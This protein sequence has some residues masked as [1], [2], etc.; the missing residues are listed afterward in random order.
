MIAWLA[1]GAV[2]LAQPST[3]QA[4]SADTV[5]LAPAAFAVVK[6][7]L[8]YDRTIPLDAM[9]IETT[10]FP[11]HSRQRIVYRGWRS[12]LPAYLA[13]PKTG[14][15][16]F[17]VVLL[18]HA[19]GSSKETWWQADGF[20]YGAVLRDSLLRAGFAV[21][22]IDTQLHGDRAAAA[23]YVPVA[24][25]FLQRQWTH[26]LRDV[27]A[28]T[29]VDLRRALD[30]LETR[31]DIEVRRASV[32]GTSMGG[33]VAALVAATDDRIRSAVICVAPLDESRF[34]PL[35]A[36][37]IAPWLNRPATLIVAGRTDEMIPLRSTERFATAVGGP[38]SK[39]LILESGHR[40][41]AE[42]VAHR[43]QWLRT[44]GR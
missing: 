34:Y 27:A 20:E 9:L 38:R 39:V 15:A 32:F 7:M 30:Y 25:M 19:G 41:P 12:R 36:I 42:Y 43:V 3:V 11:E 8:Q 16:P 21:F 14:Q 4:Q 13:L 29:S 26:R 28:E 22:A 24:T 33:G 5:S 6:A 35:R 37:A 18:V 40:P 1:I 31:P 10:D 2:L 44:H 23:E 17:P